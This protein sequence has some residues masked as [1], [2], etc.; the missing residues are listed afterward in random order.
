MTRSAERRKKQ[1]GFWDIFKGDGG[2]KRGKRSVSS[3][4]SSVEED[5]RRDRK[6]RRGRRGVDGKRG[7]SRLGKHFS[8]R[9]LFDSTFEPTVAMDLIKKQKAE[10]R[11]NQAAKKTA[12]KKAKEVRERKEKLSLGNYSNKTM[13][14]G[15][16][17]E[18]WMRQIHEEFAEMIEDYGTIVFKEY[19]ANI[20]VFW[21]NFPVF[22]HVLSPS[23]SQTSP[24]TNPPTQTDDLAAL[25]LNREQIEQM[26]E[27]YLERTVDSEF[28]QNKI[29]RNA[30]IISEGKLEMLIK[31]KT[32][33]EVAALRAQIKRLEAL[34][35]CASGSKKKQ[36]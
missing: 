20:H 5:D 23:Q 21:D 12:K 13:L 10:K 6:S 26:I 8:K 33:A 17:M 34:V 19:L 18:Q 29:K 36:S 15:K 32:E 11:K 4:H 16:T 2:K 24:L 3:S 1:G 22:D 28:T 30:L 35:Q 31:S 14:K 27:D 7:K 9:G 25:S